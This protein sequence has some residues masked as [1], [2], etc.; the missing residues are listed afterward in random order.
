MQVYILSILVSLLVAS[1]GLPSA[2]AMGNHSEV[3]RDQNGRAL[4][5]TTVWVYV[6][7]SGTLASIYSDNGTTAKPNPFTTDVLDGKYNFYA[8][9]GTY[10]IVYSHPN[11]TFDPA[12][13]LRITVLDGSDLGD[14]TTVAAQGLHDNFVVDPAIRGA[15]TANPF[16]VGDGTNYYKLG[17]DPTNG[18]FLRCAPG[19]V[20]NACNYVRKL[21]AG[22]YWEIQNASTNSI[23]RVTN[24][25]GEISNAK[26]DTEFDGNIFKYKDYKYFP[27][28][29]CN[30]GTASTAWN[31]PTSNAPTAAC[32]GSTHNKGVLEFPDGSNDLSAHIEWFLDS[33]WTGTV[34]ARVIW[35][36]ASTSTNNVLWAIAI[37]CA[38]EGD[39]SDPSYTD[40][41]FTADA[42]NSTANTYN[43]TASNNVVMTGSC[44][45]NKVMHI[46]VKRK[47]SD[48]G[49][50]LAA[51]AQGLGLALR[52]RQ[53]Q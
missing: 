24:D 41:N 31:L 21:S 16:I 11:A 26:F 17:N 27:F 43:I 51:T 22:F 53:S 10:D 14:T 45:A 42:N 20:D 38:G 39:S 13:T 34:D 9:N 36:S 23:F 8:A 25:T 30:G 28:A 29:G 33:D 49:D 6:S 37:A 44:A 15:T 4:G 12:H 50:T 18:L 2:W 19:G 3:V 48:A 32:K 46:R 52:L 1:T 5:G 47:L 40:D 35:E 7:G